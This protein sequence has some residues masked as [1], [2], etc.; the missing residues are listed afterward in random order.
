MNEG[1]G[2]NE[3]GSYASIIGTLLSIV[4]LFFAYFINDKV[5]SVENR[6]LFSTR[7]PT[8]LDKLKKSSKKF[9]G[10]L[11]NF[12]NAST[13]IE[14]HSE[15]TS[16]Y[17]TLNI[18]CEKLKESNIS[19]LEEIRKQLKKVEKGKL[20]DIKSSSRFWDNLLNRPID[21]DKSDMWLVYREVTKFIDIVD[22]KIIDRKTLLR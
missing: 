20:V 16:I 5:K 15:I 10:L 14:I 9:K 13:K 7:V 1:L 21:F 2:I 4:T 3:I 18:I 8:H 12:E 11:L 17:S 6:L 22:T 19:E